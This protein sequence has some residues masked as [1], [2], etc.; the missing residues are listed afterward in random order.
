MALP[1]SL[2]LPVCRSCLSALS[3]LYSAILKGLFSKI[4]EWVKDKTER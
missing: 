2:R 1:V 4:Y 3:E